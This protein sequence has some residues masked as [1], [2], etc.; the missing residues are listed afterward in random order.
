LQAAV[1]AGYYQIPRE[2]IH[3]EIADDLGCSKS[4]VGQ[5]LRRV[6]AALVS[7][8]TPDSNEIV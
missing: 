3:R 1:E 4:V 2:S 6:E 5:H 7:S 8:V